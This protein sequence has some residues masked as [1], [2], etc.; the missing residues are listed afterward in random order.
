MKLAEI[1]IEHRGGKRSYQPG[2]PPTG[3]R[4]ITI[5]VKADIIDRLGPEARGKIRELVEAAFGWTNQ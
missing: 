4:A 2:R 5:W 1:K 3:R